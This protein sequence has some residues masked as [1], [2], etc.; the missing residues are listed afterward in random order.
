LE[1]GF[2]LFMPST[3]PAAA[4]TE[5]GHPAAGELERAFNETARVREEV[6]STLVTRE[7]DREMF[8]QVYPF[9][10]AL[11]QTLIA[12]SALLQRERTA[13]KLLV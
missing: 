2:G 8:R 11:I 5:N 1:I 13:L 7:G 3:V 12:V 10:P 4:T 6:L 9:S